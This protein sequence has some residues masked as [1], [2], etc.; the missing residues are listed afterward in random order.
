MR[1]LSLLALCAIAFAIP[2][3][4]AKEIPDLR[5]Q[6]RDGVRRTDKDLGNLVHRDKLN[7]QQRDRFDAA[8]KDLH[9]LG[10]ALTGDKWEAERGRLERAVD[11]I[12]YL[13]K[14]APIAE[15]DRQTLGIDVYTLQVILDNWKK[16]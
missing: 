9:D 16:S 10:E 13:Q 1:H 12:E 11:N 3:V 2:A 6:V 8:V 4:H 15:G 5:D 7:E 14:N